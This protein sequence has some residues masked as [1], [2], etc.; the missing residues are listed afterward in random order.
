MAAG[1]ATVRFLR[2]SHDD[3]DS[4]HHEPDSNGATTL[5]PAQHNSPSA[6]PF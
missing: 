6:S 1:F 4:P 5:G 3:G 2:A